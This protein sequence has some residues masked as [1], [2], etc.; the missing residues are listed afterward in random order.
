MALKIY[1]NGIVDKYRA[2]HRKRFAFKDL[3]IALGDIE[4]NILL[5]DMGVAI[6]VINK[7]ATV[8][9]SVASLFF[10]NVVNGHCLIVSGRELD[11]EIFWET[12]TKENCHYDLDFFEQNLMVGIKETLE[13]FQMVL[14]KNKESLKPVKNVFYAKVPQ[15]ESMNEEEKKFMKNFFNATVQRMEKYNN[16]NEETNFQDLILFEE[17]D[18]VIKFPK[19]KKEVEGFMESVIDYY[20]EKEQFEKCEILT[21]ALNFAKSTEKLV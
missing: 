1:E 12:I 14:D 4:E 5:M 6:L 15:Y 8:L 7:N 13:I 10:R 19:E 17:N 20:M 11:P 18:F 21:N 3:A 16:E 2:Q 9:N